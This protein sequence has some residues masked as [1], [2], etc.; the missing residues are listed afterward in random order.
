METKKRLSKALAAA[1]VASRRACEE[2]IFEGRVKV[3][4]KVVDVP[5]TLVSWGQD[6]ITVDEQPIQGEERKLYYILNKPHGYVCSNTPVGTKKLVIDLFDK[7]DERLFTVGRLD[8]DTTG[9]LIVTNDGHFAN[10]VIHPSSNIL[11]EY[12][13]KTT[14]EIS[15]VH[16]KSISKGT[17]IEGCWLKPVKV[18]KI[19]KGTLRV[20]VKE[21]KKRE[22]R[23]FV[24]NA[25]LEIVELS[26][27]RIGGLR[28]GP[29]PEGTFKEMS[30]S[31]KKVIFQK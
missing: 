28:L 20:V 4:G 23:L 26:R 19:R 11:K 5:Q 14:Q 15:D 25:G 24:Q 27:V 16:L 10:K 18:E 13:V 1:G 30:E 8:R 21:G 6:K 12:I 9:L 22:V 3:N 29:I 7:Q 2:I 17:L 31:D